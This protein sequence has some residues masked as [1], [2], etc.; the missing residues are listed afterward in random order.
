M[1]ECSSWMRSHV[2]HY[3]KCLFCLI[4]ENDIKKPYFDHTKPHLFVHLT[5]K[6]Q[7]TLTIK[8]LL[9]SQFCGLM[10]IFQ[11]DR[12]ITYGS[13]YNTVCDSSSDHVTRAGN[14]IQCSGDYH[15]TYR[16]PKGPQLT[17]YSN[18]KDCFVATTTKTCSL[19]YEPVFL[20]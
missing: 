8:A 5:E 14:T 11:N 3:P 12:I 17:V 9:F 6:K 18:Y 13:K 19:W 1:S 16:S 2:I 7:N 10:Q 15:F 20:T 4:S